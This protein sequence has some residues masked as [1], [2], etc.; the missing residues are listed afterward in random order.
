MERWG[1]PI[2]LKE[3]NL[4]RR[5]S[6]L[7]VIGSE[8]VVGVS[9]TPSNIDDPYLL[10]NWPDN[11][12]AEYVGV[13]ESN[14]AGVKSRL[15]SHARRKGNKNIA[16]LIENGVE[17]YF[18]AIYGNMVVTILEP[19]FIALKSSGQFEC[20]IRLDYMRSQRKSHEKLHEQMTGKK[21][22]YA[23]WKFD[24]DGM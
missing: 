23:P 13:S 2:R 24:G 16:E 18:I 22:E 19:L 1:D 14:R 5:E 17:L 9:P 7:Y 20:N 4:S 12:K 15:S 6:G 21:L 8:R 3:Y 10:S 11:F